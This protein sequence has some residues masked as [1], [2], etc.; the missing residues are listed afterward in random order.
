LH[1]EYAKARQ[2]FKAALLVVVAFHHPGAP[3][4]V[5]RDCTHLLWLVG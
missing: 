1:H 4:E 2:E 3:A 5:E